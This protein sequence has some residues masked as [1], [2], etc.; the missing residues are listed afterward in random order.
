MPR[1]PPTDEV[2]VL[3]VAAA[4][5]VAE[6]LADVAGAAE[7]GAGT[8]DEAATVATGALEAATTAVLE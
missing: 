4:V 3:A 6:V 5:A 8:L 7:T 1:F 2:E